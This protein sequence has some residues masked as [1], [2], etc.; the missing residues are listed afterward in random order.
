MVEV[1]NMRTLYV[2][3]NPGEDPKTLSIDE[4]DRRVFSCY[5]PPY[6]KGVE[7]IGSYYFDHG[8]IR[9]RKQ[10]IDFWR[11]FLR[12]SYTGSQIKVMDE[13]DTLVRAD[14]TEF[15]LPVGF[16]LEGYSEGRL[17]LSRDGKYGIQSVT[18]EWIAQPIFADGGPFIGGLAPLKTED[19]RWGVIDTEG[20]IVLPFT[21]DAI[22]QVSSGLIACWREENGW[23]ILK[24]ME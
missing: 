22:S 19:G 23:S 24:I 14:G 10:I 20:N 12:L 5:Q 13:Y 21:Y 17:L 9:V 2:L 15:E 11:Y 16:R 18:G 7:S 8:L 4:Q 3:K 1:M 6:T